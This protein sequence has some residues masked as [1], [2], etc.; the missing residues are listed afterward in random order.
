MHAIVPN[1][2]PPPALLVTIFLLTA[3]EFLQAGMIGFAAGPIMGEIGASPEEYSLSAAVYAC[4]A[5]ATISKHRWLVERLGWRVFVLASLG[6][7]IVGCLICASGHSYDAFVIGRAV[8]GLGGAAFMTSGRVI[9]NRIAPGPFRFTG[10]KFF[11]TGLASG[12]A[13]APGLAAFVVAHDEWRG[14]FGIFIAVALLAGCASALSLPNQPVERDL[15]SQS[16]P[17]VFMALASGSFVL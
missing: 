15:R 9:I 4:V 13:V 17:V 8:M 10:I 7:F 12:I 11:A 5:I 14:I 3:L 1:K 16:H 6:T 2:A